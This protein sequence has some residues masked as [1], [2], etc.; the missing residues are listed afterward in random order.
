MDYRNPLLD[1]GNA[2]NF[3]YPDKY[4]PTRGHDLYLPELMNRLPTYDTFR[5]GNG[6]SF[7]EETLVH[8]RLFGSTGFEYFVVGLEFC[9]DPP[10]T[11]DRE[12]GWME[13][14]LY[15]W[16][17]LDGSYP[18]GEMGTSDVLP[19]YLGMTKQVHFMNPRTGHRDLRLAM[20]IERDLHWT[21]K[22]LS[23]AIRHLRLSR[24]Q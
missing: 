16:C 24:N 20:L 12:T 10:Q 1:S 15:G 18:D 21:P 22:P 11:A 2:R 7:K 9:G 13:Q 4:R 14:A 23:E 17:Q 3:A 6:S 5:V 19:E 8:M